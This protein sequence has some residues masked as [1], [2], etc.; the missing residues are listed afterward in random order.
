MPPAESILLVYVYTVSELTP[1]HWMTNKGSF[2]GKAN[3][4]PSTSH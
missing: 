3:S 2:Q 4:P 1:W